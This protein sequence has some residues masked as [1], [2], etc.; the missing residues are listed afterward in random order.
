MLE[1]HEFIRSRRSVRRFTDEPIGRHQVERILQTATRAPSAHNRQPW[2]FLVITEADLK[3]ALAEAM[4]AEFVSDLEADGVSIVERERAASRSRLRITSAP[5][6][7]VLCMDA[8][9]MDHYDDERRNLA[10][11]T[12]AIQSVANAGTTLLL[13]AHAEGLGGVW[14]CAPLFAQGAVMKALELPAGWEPQA[15]LLLGRP[16]EVSVARPRRAIGEVVIYR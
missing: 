9:Q 13:A 1:S 16:A 4:A 2:R 12:M 6:A 15:L 3:A 14:I 11:R 10:E 7:I 5:V 8:A